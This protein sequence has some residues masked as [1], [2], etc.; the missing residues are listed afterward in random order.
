LIERFQIGTTNIPI[1]VGLILMMY[2]PLAKVRYETLGH[3]FRNRRVVALSLFQNWVIG[4]VVMFL[5]AIFLLRDLPEYA[6]G[7]ILVGLARCIAMV[8]VWNDLASGDRDLVAG[9]VALNAIFQVLFYGVYAYIFI[10][11]LPPLFGMEGA[12][13]PVTVGEIAQSVA[14]YLGIPFLAGLIS[15]F[16]LLR[17]K[18]K[19]YHR[20]HVLAQRRLDRP[21]AVRCA[22]DRPAAGH[23]LR[24]HVP[25]DLLRCPHQA[26]PG[27]L[28]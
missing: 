6:V 25:G 3:V 23:L 21:A 14:I 8:L 27:G 12:I 7:L 13:V 24:R 17:A 15:R 4:P 11:V 26:D 18:G 22:S 2:P 20:G 16:A 1:A 19:E 9:L 10:T 5:L 28:R